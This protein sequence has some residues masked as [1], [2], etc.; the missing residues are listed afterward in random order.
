MIFL[1]NYPT[2]PAEICVVVAPEHILVENNVFRVIANSQVCQIYQNIKKKN[3]E[4]ISFLLDLKN[5]VDM[6][7][8]FYI[9]TFSQLSGSRDRFCCT[10]PV[11]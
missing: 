3:L 2:N 7:S 10:F 9:F 8:H 4:I 11:I 1:E 6:K 5:I